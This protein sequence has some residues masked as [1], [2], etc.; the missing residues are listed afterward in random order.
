MGVFAFFM[1]TALAMMPMLSSTEARLGREPQACMFFALDYAE[2][3][4]ANERIEALR[5]EQVRIVA[6]FEELM[7][8]GT[9]P[10]EQRL[11]EAR[12]MLRSR[13]MRDLDR[14]IRRATRTLDEGRSVVAGWR[15]Q[16]CPVASPDGAEGLTGQERCDALAAIFVDQLRIDRR[17]HAQTRLYEALETERQTILKA[18]I[19]RN[20]RNDLLEL[21][22]L[23][24]EAV[25]NLDGLQRFIMLRDEA[26]DLIAG[27]EEESCVE[28]ERS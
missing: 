9:R 6:T 20:D 14:E 27:V 5:D 25:E 23:R 1:V 28:A 15:G 7:D 26:H 24:T 16:Y 4:V 8:D 2:E 22:R 12:S 18:R 3:L 19:T 21:L 11:D 10:P 13:E 17:T